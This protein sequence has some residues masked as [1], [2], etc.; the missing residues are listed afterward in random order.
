MKFIVMHIASV[1]MVMAIALIDKGNSPLAFMLGAICCVVSLHLVL[2]AAYL[3][4][5]KSENERPPN[6]P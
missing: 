5:K 2:Y 6:K 1:L 3:I 4:N